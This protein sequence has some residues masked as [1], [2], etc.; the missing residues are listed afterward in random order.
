M[1]S[2]E[3]SPFL[4]RSLPALV[5]MVM[6]GLALVA[7]HRLGGEFQL[8]GI[9]A[10]FSAIEPWRLLAA[11][12]L[13]AGSHAAL[14]G[15]ERLAL[16][17]VAR[18]LPLRTTALTSFIANAVGNNVGVA[19][20]SGG[21]IRYRMYSPLGLGA[22]EIARIV[23]FCTATFGLGACTLAGLSLIVDAGEASSLLHATTAVSRMLGSVAL[24]AAGAYLLACSLRHEAFEWRGHAVRLPAPRIAASQLVLAVLDLAFA[25]GTLY[26]LLPESANVSFVAFLGL[27]MVALAVSVLSLVPGGLG[28]LE[29]ILVLLLPGVAPT[30]LLG[31]LLAYRLVYYVLPFVVAVALMSLREV[32]QHR[33]RL[34]R[35]WAWTQRSLDFVVP[36]A[37]ALLVFGAGFLLL[38]SG[39]TPAAAARL[40]A[41]DRFVPLAVL[42]ASHL[43][44]SAVGVLLLILAHGLARRLD[45]AWQVTLLLL[46]AGAV[47]SL[48]KGLD[49]EEA[50][51]LGVV[52]L[53][54]YG[55]RAQFYRTSSLV[56]E[57]LA[58]AWLASAAI[59]VGASIWIGLLA[60][61]HVPYAS[62]LWWQ[63]ALDAHAPRMLRASLLAV[64]L[65]GS[66]ATMRLLAPA[67]GSP[68]LPTDADLERAVPIIR[69]S[70]DTSANLALLGDKSLLFSASGNSFLMY[71]ISRRSWVAMGDPV[72]PAA[73]RAELVWQF[74]DLADRAGACSV[75]YEVA[76]E[77]LPLYVDAGLALS[78]LGEEAR[79]RL[80]DFSL[81]GSARS[82][83]R[84][85]H[86]KAQRD[87][88]SLRIVAWRD[89]RPD[90]APAADFRRVAAEQV[91]GGKRLL[92]RPVLGTLPAALLVGAGRTR[93]PARCLREPLGKRRTRGVVGRP[94]ATRHRRAQGRDGLSVHRT[95]VVGQGPGLRLVQS[96]HGAVGRPGGASARA[97]VAQGRPP[98][99]PL[100][101][102]LLQ[103]RRPAP[104]Q[105]EIPA[106]VATALPRRTWRPGADARVAGRNGT[107]LRAAAGHRAQGLARRHGSR[108]TTGSFH[109]HELAAGSRPCSWSFACAQRHCP[110]RRP[111][112][113]TCHC[114][115]WRSHRMP[116]IP[117]RSCSRA[118]AAGQPSTRRWRANSMRMASPW[119][120][121]MRCI[122]SGMHARPSGAASDLDRVVRHYARAWR[123]SRVLLLG[124][125]QGADTLPFM[126]N[127]LPADTARQS[128][129]PSLIGIGAEAFFEFHVSHW[130][131]TPQGGLPTRSEVT[132]GRLGSV[133][134]IYGRRDN[135]SACRGLRG[136]G[137]HEVALAGG[138]HFDGD[139]VT[140]STAV[141]SA[142]AL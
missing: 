46:G 114:S 29:S 19:M 26:V 132:S 51:L 74:R 56:A 36:Q 79:V 120:A 75:F 11:V 109:C 133:F 55:T 96:R 2:V 25:C 67:R 98:G 113:T 1:R 112:S 77:N 97:G 3:P 49:Y 8:H 59:A 13:T 107:D 137:V 44:G 86:R 20:L 90:A 52:A 116:A 58:P 136:T 50:L 14:V 33:H 101:R 84:Q 123:K 39:A 83:L 6:F 21:A 88:L 48:L 115:N 37:I 102:Q 111:A 9:L 10:E 125:S 128:A 63:F 80:D 15:Y 78:K 87:G 117:S 5:P 92:A 17:Y 65:V 131:G 91:G 99:L 57:S 104:V 35:A 134:C 23:A 38:L 105:G 43:A 72:G 127:R 68:S 70:T 106:R 110:P 93:G 30:Q 61:R 18:A 32:Q 100:R 82:S 16:S 129:P 126:I 45:G 54:L 60:Y 73:E 118:T 103:L 41:L 34:S 138:H 95:D 122:T 130:I 12:A 27:Y 141:V 28:V 42:E 69:G 121:G 108:V 40:A 119:W 124:Y 31:A 4:R 24:L 7:L 94:D 22:A 81:D 64:L 62:E 47:A 142:L 76:G 139:Y 66:F 71:G 89:R 53:A 135:D 85:S 140:L